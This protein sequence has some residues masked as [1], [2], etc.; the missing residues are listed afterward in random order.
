MTLREVTAD[1][2]RAVCA[3]AVAPGQ[4]G[5]VA[6]NSVSIAEAYFEP[7]AWFRAVYADE[8]PVGF[9]MLYDDP[10]TPEYFLWRLMIAGSH[11]GRGYGRR[12]LDLLVDHVRSRPGGSELRSSY[13]PGEAGPGGFYRRY[14]FEETGE[15]NQ[16]QIVIRLAL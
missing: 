11:Q 9:V 8:E 6:P 1:T 7:K 3:L 14:G 15:L 12:A 4:E 13:V 16:G 5:F 10:D 2:V